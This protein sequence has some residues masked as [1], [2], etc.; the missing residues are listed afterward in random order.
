MLAVSGE[1]KGI[2]MSHGSRLRHNITR[3][4]SGDPPACFVLA[5]LPGLTIGDLMQRRAEGGTG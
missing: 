1:D 5:G 3:V 2:R 4:A